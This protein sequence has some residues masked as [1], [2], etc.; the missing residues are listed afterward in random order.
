MSKV[1]KPSIKEIQEKTNVKNI[2]IKPIKKGNKI[3]GYYFLFDYHLQQLEI[4]LLPVNYGVKELN[5]YE[6]LTKEYG[7]TSNQSQKIIDMVPPKE[8]SKILY[9]IQLLD[10]NKQLRNKGGYTLSI[11]NSKYD[12]NI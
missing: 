11:F 9:D 5:Q 1:I 7:L 10:L 12:M 6:I 8:I 3:E 2:K 4:P